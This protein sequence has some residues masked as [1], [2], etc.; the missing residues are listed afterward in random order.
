MFRVVLPPITRSAYNCIYSI[1]YLSHRYCYL[2]LSWKSWNRFECAVVGVR[3]VASCWIYEYN[4]ILL[5]AHPILHISRIRVNVFLLIGQTS[6]CNN[7]DIKLSLSLFSS[8]H[9]YN[10]WSI[11]WSLVPHGQ[12]GV[13]SILNRYK[14]DLIFLC[15]VTMDVKLWLSYLQLDAQN[16][17]LDIIHLLKSSTCFEHYP[18]HLQEVYV[19]IV[20]MQPLVLCRWL[21][22]APVGKE[23]FL[24]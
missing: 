9:S 2:P 22:C 4:G 15:P 11:V 19:V 21:S 17:Y 3:N 13:S 8:S 24:S 23:L 14:Y 5:G 18:A 1:W 16:S 10:N 6:V 7:V 12:V 20:Y